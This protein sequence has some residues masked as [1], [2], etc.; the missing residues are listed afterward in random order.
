MGTNATLAPEAAG[1][2]ETWF[3][4]YSHKDTDWLDRLSTFLKPYIKQ[5]RLNVWADPYIQVGDQWRRNISAALGR[6][7]V[8]VLLVSQDFFASDFIWEEELPTLLQGAQS[9]WVILFAIPISASTFEIT[10]LAEYQWARDPNRPLDQLEKPNRNAVLVDIVKKIYEAVLKSGP[11]SA[12][13]PER[14][15]QRSCWRPF[16]LLRSQTV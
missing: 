7:C 16:R 13:R 1:D 3:V 4:S 8:G 12:V 14:I 2:R 15:A 11:A 10:P 9:G 5:G 6:T